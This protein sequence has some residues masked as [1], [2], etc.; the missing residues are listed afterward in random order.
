MSGTSAASG[1][2][3]D[4]SSVADAS[5]G[6][7]K[8]AVT[9][10]FTDTSGSYNAGASVSVAITYAEV[11]DALSVPSPGGDDH[12]AAPPPSTVQT[13]GGTETRTVQTGRDGRRHDP[14]HQRPVRRRVGRDHHPELRRRRNRPTGELPTGISIPS[15]RGAD[16]WLTPLS[17]TSAA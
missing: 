15:W 9:V 4:V 17:S 12:R 7:A 10:S 8:Y 16:R 11:A 3:T 5:S 2:V 1:T 13:D 6:V 14:D